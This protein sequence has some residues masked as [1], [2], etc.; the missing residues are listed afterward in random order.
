MADL[1]LTN[2]ATI[3]NSVGVGNRAAIRMALNGTAAPN[4]RAGVVVS[5]GSTL[6]AAALG[7]IVLRT[8]AGGAVKEQRLATADGVTATALSDGRT[9]LEFIA[10]SAFDA[11]EVDVA[12][13]LNVLNTLDVYYAF[14]VEANVVTTAAGYLSRLTAPSAADYQIMSGGGLVCAGT[15]VT[16][17]ENAV[18]SDLNDFAVLS[19]A[20]GVGCKSSLQVRLE[21]QSPAGYQAGFVIGNGS[22]LDLNVLKTL[23]VT[24]YLNGVAQESA[25]AADLLQFTL[26]PNNRYQVSFPTNTA[27]DRVELEQSSLLNALNNL[28]VYYGFGIEPRAFRDDEPVLSD[29]AAPQPN[30]N[31]QTSGSSLACV[32]CRIIN[33]ERA[34]DNVFN[35]NDYA[36]MQFPLTAVGTQRIRLRLN[37]DGEA[38]NRAG[39]VLRT[40]TGLL[41]TSLLSNVTLRTYSASGDLLET[42]SGASLLTTGV[43]GGGLQEIGF[44]T[45]QDFGWVEVE[46]RGGL[47]LFSEAQIF[48][49]FAD[50]PAQGFPTDI[51]VPAAPLPVEFSAF[52][53]KAAGNAVDVAWETASERASSHYEVERA[54]DAKEGFVPV[55]RVE[56]AGNTATR[57]RYNLRDADVAKL[58]A[59]TLYY[60]LRQVDTDGTAVYTAPVAV[61]WQPGLAL[62]L[63]VYPNPASE[64]ATVQVAGGTWAPGATLHLYGSRGELLRRQAMHGALEQVPLRGLKTGLY[65]VVLQ[66]AAGHKIGTQRLMVQGR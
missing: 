44:L 47:N 18:S 1:D 11:V 62:S 28:N 21:G 20:V 24:T 50:D 61:R 60:R 63:D 19:T 52:T 5:S 66:D 43:L 22:V 25:T 34:A 16:G 38:G 29:F 53:A 40:N 8:Y 54:T 13:T 6:N 27:F 55:G 37:G 17:A 4:F 51:R 31:Y 10:A 65:Y 42:A 35:V 32:N 41:S 56:A 64:T 23:K 9:R 57:Q 2:Y 48:Y 30:V 14:G 59:G 12:V 49:A 15:G 7:A 3:Q 46:V 33:P 39:V 26:L 58:P 45:T 36:E